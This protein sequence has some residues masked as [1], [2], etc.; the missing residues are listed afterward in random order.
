[1][2]V[3]KSCG[4]PGLVDRGRT[5]NG[6]TGLPATN[7]RVLTALAWLFQSSCRSLLTLVHRFLAFPPSICLCLSLCW[8]LGHG[9]TSTD[10]SYDGYHVACPGVSPVYKHEHCR[11]ESESNLDLTLL[12][13]QSV[14]LPYMYSYM[15]LGLIR[16]D[17]RIRDLA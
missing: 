17:N 12:H 3:S 15:G 11:S 9:L 7:P 1:M 4:P 10:P 6:Q 16:L 14:V 8:A 13:M 5:D 2:V